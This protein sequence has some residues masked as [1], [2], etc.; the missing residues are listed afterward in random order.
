[1]PFFKWETSLFC[2]L[3]WFYVRCLY[4]F[5]AC[6][7]FYNSSSFFF[8]LFVLFLFCVFLR[9]GMVV[10]LEYKKGIGEILVV[11]KNGNCFFF[12]F[13]LVVYQVRDIKV[14]SERFDYHS[15]ARCPGW[16]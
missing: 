11:E 1:M 10:L 9:L 4:I 14:L 2:R 15:I 5:F 8:G 7:C 13:F 12:F 16:L 3:D 6:V